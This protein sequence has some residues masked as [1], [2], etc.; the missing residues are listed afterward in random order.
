MTTNG[1]ERFYLVPGDVWDGRFGPACE[2]VGEALHDVSLQHVVV[3]RLADGAL[4]VCTL[5]RFVGAY[6]QKP[7]AVVE[8]KA[9]GHISDSIHT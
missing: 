1:T 4:H 3:Y 6:T 9:A 8:E 2:V 7:K 5:A